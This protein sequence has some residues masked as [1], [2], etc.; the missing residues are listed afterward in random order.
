M[1]SEQGKG[2]ANTE[3][4]LPTVVKGK[5]KSKQNITTPQAQQQKRRA[6]TLGAATPKSTQTSKKGGAKKFAITSVPISQEDAGEEEEE[7]ENEEDE[8]DDVE[9]ST[10]RPES[11][12]SNDAS[13]EKKINN[14]EKKN[15]NNK[16]K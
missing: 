7:G 6:L 13:K 5:S 4:A 14:V 9:E 12:T 16:T 2:E 11:R 1:S 3:W 15:K 10:E 8:G